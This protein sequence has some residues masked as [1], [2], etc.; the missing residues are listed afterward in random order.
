V[1]TLRGLGPGERG[2]RPAMH[3]ALFSD[4]LVKPLGT[5]FPSAGGAVATMVRAEA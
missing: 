4:I 2:L 3:L 5:F 1:V